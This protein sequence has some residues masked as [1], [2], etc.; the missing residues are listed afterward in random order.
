MSEGIP[1]YSELLHRVK[2]KDAELSALRA[3][4][5][6]ALE[7]AAGTH[8]FSA[9]FIKALSEIHK[10]ATG[11]DSW[12]IHPEVVEGVAALRARWEE[13]EKSRDGWIQ[14]A[15]DNTAVAMERAAFEDRAQAA[16]SRALAAEKE[17]DQLRAER[18]AYQGAVARAEDA[19]LAK[20]VKRMED[21]VTDAIAIIEGT[22]PYNPFLFP[23][24]ARLA[25]TP[26][27]E[28]GAK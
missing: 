23:A 4:L 25:L 9:Q 16:E 6:T 3:R 7:D 24:K 15:K 19:V 10:I 17:R 1:D 28:G 20:R 13:V 18:F 14:V 12:G 8:R 11:K 2:A 21:L 26:P 22:P 27:A 5:D